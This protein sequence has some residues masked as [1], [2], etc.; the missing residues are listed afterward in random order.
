LQVANWNELKK[1]AHFKH[2][3][4]NK[5]KVSMQRNIVYL[6]RGIKWNDEAIGFCISEYL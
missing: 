3:V 2:K 6:N 5:L 1:E 4:L